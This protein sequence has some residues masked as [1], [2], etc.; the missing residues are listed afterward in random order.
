MDTSLS[1]LGP[2][3]NCF[4]IFDNKTKIGANCR[5]LD[6]FKLVQQRDITKVG[7]KHDRLIDQWIYTFDSLFLEITVCIRCELVDYSRP[8]GTHN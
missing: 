7:V 2:K 6:C 1:F 4:P 8:R 5:R 3:F